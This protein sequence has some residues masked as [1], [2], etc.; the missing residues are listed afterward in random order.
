MLTDWLYEQVHQ[1]L[2]YLSF[3]HLLITLQAFTQHFWL[4]I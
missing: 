3:Y 2:V 1:K 4:F